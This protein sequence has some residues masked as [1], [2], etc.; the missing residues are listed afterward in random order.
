MTAYWQFGN[1]SDMETK[2]VE[3]KF[4]GPLPKTIANRLHFRKMSAEEWIELHGSGTLRKN[5]RIGFAWKNQYLHERIAYEFGYAF[6]VLP[7]TRIVYNDAIT[8]GDCHAITEAGWFMERYLNLSI[9]EEDKFEVKYII[10]EDADG[11]RR[12]GVGLIC[13]ETSFE[14]PSDNI[15]FAIV[16]E[17]DNK[18]K[19]WNSAKNPF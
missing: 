7:R 17:F 9:F 14:L 15:L 18:T 8:E 10:A 16:A 2:V 4:V 12:E 11:T 13:R 1:V 3:T 6:E 19:T 5:K